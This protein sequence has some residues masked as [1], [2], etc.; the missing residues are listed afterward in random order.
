M[1][2]YRCPVCGEDLETGERIECH[3]MIL[4]KQDP[5]RDDPQNMRLVHQ[6][7]HEQIHSSHG[8][9]ENGALI[10]AA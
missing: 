2:R 5:A 8:L 9:T 6:I 3:H 10:R 4:T 7:C 1:S